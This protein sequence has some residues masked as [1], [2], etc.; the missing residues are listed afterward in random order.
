M[1]K[2]HKRQ[3]KIKI[4]RS[5]D[6]KYVVTLFDDKCFNVIG[7]P[8]W[9]LVSLWYQIS[10]LLDIDYEEARYILEQKF[11]RGEE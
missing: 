8:P 11:W 5:S 6:D 3:C 7:I 1:I 4:T 2:L 10:E 9:E